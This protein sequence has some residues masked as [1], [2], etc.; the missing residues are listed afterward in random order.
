MIVWI[1]TQLGHFVKAILCD[2]GRNTNFSFLPFIFDVIELR[3]RTI[4]IRK[5]NIK[6]AHP[7]GR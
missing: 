6:N 3:L 2:D 5:Q 7:M 4:C 1:K